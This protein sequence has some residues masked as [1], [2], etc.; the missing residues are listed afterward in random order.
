M[1]SMLLVALVLAGCSKAPAPVDDPELRKAETVARHLTSMRHLKRSACGAIN[2]TGKPSELVS[3]LF[4]DVGVAEWP[5]GEES[6]EGEREQARSIRVPL[7]P[8]DARL[9]HGQPDP[10]LKRQL[11]L[12]GDDAKAE[13]V[14][15]GYSDPGK[16][17]VYTAR[18]P[19]P[20]LK[21][22]GAK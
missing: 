14:A 5:P 13:I 10:R 22:V 12:R 15:E 20:D 4:S 18:W 6:S 2:Q 1:R 19:M 3:C 8:K 16:P 17:P 7:F 11:V 21:P 9:V